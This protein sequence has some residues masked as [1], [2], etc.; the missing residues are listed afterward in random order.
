MVPD[1]VGMPELPDGAPYVS[2]PDQQL[3]YDLMQKRLLDLF[4]PGGSFTVTLGRGSQDE[5]MFASTVAHTIAW[6]VAAHLGEVRVTAPRRSA[7]VEPAPEHRVIWDYVEDELAR[8]N[9]AAP[10]AAASVSPAASV[11]VSPATA[12]D[13]DAPVR[14]STPHSYAA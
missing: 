11:P 10:V 8:Q 6:D 4:G 9:L 13:E 3:L 14:A 5:S 2:E 1:T 7:V 12:A